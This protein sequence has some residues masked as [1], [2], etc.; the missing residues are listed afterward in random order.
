MLEGK[1]YVLDVL[2]EEVKTLG[3]DGQLIPTTDF[4]KILEID[5]VSICVPM[6]LRKT[7]DPD[8]SYIIDAITKIKSIF[9]KIY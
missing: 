3:E 7:K 9:I 4:S 1:S 8:I 2:S 6:P 5:A